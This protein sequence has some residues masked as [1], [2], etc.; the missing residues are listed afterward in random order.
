MEA[1]DVPITVGD[2]LSTTTPPTYYGYQDYGWNPT[3]RD[4][5][6]F[7][8]LLNDFVQ[9]GA[10]NTAAISGDYF[11]GKGWPEYYN[12]SSGDIVI[13]SG[14]NI[15]LNSPTVK[16][17]GPPMTETITCSGAI[18]TMGRGDPTRAGR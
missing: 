18:R 5:N 2:Q 14:A 8:V 3:T 7:A 12:P 11:G 6:S 16:T 10:N 4:P 17:R 15:F 13:P 1:S 9:N